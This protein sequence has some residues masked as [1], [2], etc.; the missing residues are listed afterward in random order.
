MR[1][2]AHSPT[3]VLGPHSWSAVRSL[4]PDGFVFVSKREKNH[5]QHVESLVFTHFHFFV[6][7][8]CWILPPASWEC[9]PSSSFSLEP[10]FFSWLPQAY[11]FRRKAM[12][13]FE[14]KSIFV[15]KQKKISKVQM[16]APASL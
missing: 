14:G 10:S 8:S 16:L 3:S 12:K 11:V 13:Y 7:F 9:V 6:G 1:L 5:L 2:L 15:K 4:V